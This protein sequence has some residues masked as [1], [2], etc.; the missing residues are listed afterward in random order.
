MVKEATGGQVMPII[1]GFLATTVG[2]WAA[3]CGMA[4]IA[5][6][7][8]AR[9]YENKGA[10]RVVSQIETKA[11]VLNEKASEAYDAANKPGAADRLRKRYC[12]DC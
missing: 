10:S 6:F 12:L 8:F 5:W 3:I 1:V 9:Y 4:L 11:K 7:G 2:R